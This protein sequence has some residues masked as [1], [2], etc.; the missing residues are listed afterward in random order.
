MTALDPEIVGGG[1]IRPQIIRDHPIGNEAIFLQKLAHQFQRGVLVSLGLDQHIEDFALGVDDAPQIDHSA[2]DFQIDFIQMLYRVR[3]GAA[4]TQVRR[5]HRPEMIYPASDGFAG[6]R[7]PAFRQQ[8]FDIAKA[9]GEPEI[10]PDRL[11]NDLARIS[12]SVVADFLHRHG[13]RTA[14]GTATPDCRDNAFIILAARVWQSAARPRYLSAL[15]IRPST[16]S[17]L[18][19]FRPRENPADAQEELIV[20]VSALLGSRNSGSNAARFRGRVG[21]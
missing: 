13:Y 8:N 21:C 9:Q 1:A 6:D 16:A 15:L 18:E 2:G 12:V 17:R 20:F 4:F 11:L 5:D 10:K 3:L 19:W 7:N 14:E